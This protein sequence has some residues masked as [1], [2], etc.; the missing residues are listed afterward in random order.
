MSITIDDIAKEAN[1]SR[2]TV[3]RVINNFPYIK[4][5]TRKKVQKIIN[6]HN[7]NINYT[8]KNLASGKSLDLI[9]ILT[10]IQQVLDSPYFVKII[11]AIEE[12]LNAK[13]HVLFLT[14]IVDF[15]D[16]KQK[17]E[18]LEMLKN[19]HLSRIIKGFVI[20][21][22]TVGDYHLK[23]LSDNGAKGMIIGGK[24]TMNNFGYVDINNKECVKIVMDHLIKNG[25]KKIA[26]I[27]GPVDY[28]T[29]AKE[30]EEAYYSVLSD[31]NIKIR[32]DYIYYGD[33]SKES[34]VKALRKFLRLKDSPTA[35][36]ASNDDMALGVYEEAKNQK[37]K[38]PKDLSVCG[39]DDIEEASKADPPL[40]TISQ[41]F[42]QFG[43]YSADA[44]V[45][46]NFNTKIEVIGKLEKRGSVG[47]IK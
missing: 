23:Y 37:I 27:T 46:Q 38:I 36:F 41:P 24:W 34:G 42:F 30:R 18:R 21:G 20:L 8:A 4:N 10:G 25:H 43:D 1:V 7:Y 13:E 6:K 3:S 26:L 11:K 47:K 29:A 16:E 15:D 17:F 32:K 5:E 33:F 22:P 2:M 19:L 44:I 12:S 40:T 14:N 45:N 28:T 39:F 35:I 9:C 31:N